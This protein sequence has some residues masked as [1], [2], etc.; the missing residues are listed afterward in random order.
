[1]RTE[2]QQRQSEYKSNSY[3]F[4]SSRS[5]SSHKNTKTSR[6][7][8]SVL[9][10]RTQIIQKLKLWLK[11]KAFEQ[12]NNTQHRF[13]LAL[14]RAIRIRCKISTEGKGKKCFPRST[15]NR[16]ALKQCSLNWRHLTSVQFTINRK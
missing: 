11:K 4:H 15:E 3:I 12:S 16:R 6:V 9:L 10:A 2:S 5:S 7:R 8:G 1:M 14:K 13:V